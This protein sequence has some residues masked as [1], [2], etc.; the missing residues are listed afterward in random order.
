MTDYVD[1][2]ERAPSRN[3]TRTDSRTPPH[4]LDA[5]ASLLG[6]ML[7]DETPV[8]LAIERQLDPLDFYKPAHGHIYGAIKALSSIG[9]AIDAYRR[10]KNGR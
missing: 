7:L 3:A 6:A 8:G 10:M 2:T 9:E 1:R 5:E 4:N